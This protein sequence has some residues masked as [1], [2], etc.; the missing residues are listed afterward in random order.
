ML[1]ACE[2]IDLYIDFAQSYS[3]QLER[4]DLE[5]FLSQLGSEEKREEFK[6]LVE[7]VNSLVRTGQEVSRKVNACSISILSALPKELGR[8]A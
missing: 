2:V 5:P 3:G 1:K 4:I 8:S 7:V 6:E